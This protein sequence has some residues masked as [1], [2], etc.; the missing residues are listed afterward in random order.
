MNTTTYF[1]KLLI[2]PPAS[3]LL[4]AFLGLMLRKYRFGLSLTTTCLL[5]LTLL[6]LP[7]VTQSLA[8]SLETDPMLTPAM[9]QQFK[10]QAIIVIGGGGA[11]GLE[12][13]QS[14]TVNDRTLL[15][16]RYAAKLARETQ[17][18]ILVAGGSGFKKFERSEAQNMSE[19]LQNEFNVPVKWQE[20]NSKNTLENAQFSRQI[21]Q[22]Q[23]IDKI[24]LV[25]QAY[26]MPRAKLAFQNAGFQVLAAP[27]A[28][29]SHSSFSSILQFVPI[30][31]ALDKSFLVLHE[32]LGLLWYRLT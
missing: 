21:L 10:P 12:F 14:R 1:I 22:P 29:L 20:A 15:R 26:H 13:Q 31:D 24:L 9:I 23:G 28:F 7:V 3:L 5:M 2:L 27:T 4:L 19:A 6:S 17:L 11:Y 32:Y 8:E 16:L 30:S 18:P 25:T